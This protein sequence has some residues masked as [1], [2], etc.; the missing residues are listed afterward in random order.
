MKKFQKNTTNDIPLPHDEIKQIIQENFFRK[1]MQNIDNSDVN[2]YHLEN[3]FSDETYYL[4]MKIVPLLERKVLYL[5]YVE[6]VR[7]NDIGRKLKLRKNEIISLR[8]KGIN[9]FKH[10]LDILSQAKHW[11][12]GKKDG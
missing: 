4:A 12:G 2:L 5:S 8:H 10:N 6:N 9:H 11:K 1:S 7:L 3:I